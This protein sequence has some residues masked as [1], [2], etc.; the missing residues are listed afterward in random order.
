[1]NFVV[2]LGIFSTMAK[3]RRVRTSLRSKTA[4]RDDWGRIMRWDIVM[5]ME[6]SIDGD[7]PIAGWFIVENPK[8]KWVIEG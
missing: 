7:T 3:L 8:M 2:M 1:M 4:D 5:S 6:V